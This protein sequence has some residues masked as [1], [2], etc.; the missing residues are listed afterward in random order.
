[1]DSQAN[2]ETTSDEVELKG[3]NSD[4]F[5]IVVT[6]GRMEWFGCDK[7]GEELT[8]FEGTRRKLLLVSILALYKRLGESYMFFSQILIARELVFA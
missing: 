2:D 4:S 8:T 3:S 7:L 1:M 6:K 5:L